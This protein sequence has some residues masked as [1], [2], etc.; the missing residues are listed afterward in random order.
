MKGVIENLLIKQ[1]I[2]L[3]HLLHV[4]HHD[5]TKWTASDDYIKEVDMLVKNLIDRYIQRASLFG[6][7]RVS[8][9]AKLPNKKVV[10]NLSESDFSLAWQTLEQDAAN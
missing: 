1:V 4:N 2:E 8:S 5:P 6:T 10:L 3:K 7:H 9:D